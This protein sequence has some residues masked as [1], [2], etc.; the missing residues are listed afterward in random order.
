MSILCIRDF[1]INKVKDP[2]EPPFIRIPGPH[3]YKDLNEQ[4]KV[5]FSS[6]SS[7]IL[8]SYMFINISAIVITGEQQSFNCTLLLIDLC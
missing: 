2:L 6:F 4:Y 3:S 7:S 1:Q 5:E 8:F